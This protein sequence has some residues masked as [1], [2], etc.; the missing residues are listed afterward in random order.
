MRTFHSAGVCLEQGS[1]LFWLR[2]GLS[3]FHEPQ[4]SKEGS[5]MND[6]MAIA[7][8]REEGMYILR[9]GDCLW[10]VNEDGMVDRTAQGHT[11]VFKLLALIQEWKSSSGQLDDHSSLEDP[12]N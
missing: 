5:E 12:S 2:Q 3:Q 9:E 11:S 4:F 7:R 10:R 6:T 1:P 8:S